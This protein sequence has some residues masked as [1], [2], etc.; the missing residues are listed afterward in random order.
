MLK[1]DEVS[2]QSVCDWIN[3][4]RASPRGDDSYQ[5]KLINLVNTPEFEEFETTCATILL[6]YKMSGKTI[7]QAMTAA[8][9]FGVAL[10]VQIPPANS[11]T[12]APPTNTTKERIM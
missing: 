6:L 8:I 3:E 9:V 1:L 12:S 5:E 10:G 7:L 11:L 4:Q 2:A